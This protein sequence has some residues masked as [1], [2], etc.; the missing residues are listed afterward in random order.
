MMEMIGMPMVTISIN[1]DEVTETRFTPES[2]SRGLKDGKEDKFLERLD[3]LLAEDE[4]NRGRTRL[5]AMLYVNRYIMS[6]NSFYIKFY[7]GSYRM[8]DGHT[9][10]HS[11]EPAILL[12]LADHYMPICRRRAA[13]R[14]K[15]AGSQ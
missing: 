11:K 1:G 13:R 9:G 5:L 15:G 6:G 12:A 8:L 14:G 4:K 3:E 2:T 7:E 10:Y